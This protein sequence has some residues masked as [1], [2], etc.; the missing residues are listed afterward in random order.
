MLKQGTEKITYRLSIS[1]L[2]IILSLFAISIPL[3]IS[4]YQDYIKTKNALIEIEV[5][6][7]VAD[8]A[9]KI[10][11]ERGPANKAMSSHAEDLAKNRQA[12][13]EYRNG[14]DQQVKLTISAL[15]HAGFNT[16]AIGVQQDVVKRL[17]QGRQ[18]VDLYLNTPFTQRKAIQFDQ[19]ILHMFNAWDATHDVLKKVVMYSKNK[20]SSLTESYTLILILADL[21]DQAG[22]VASN[23]MAHVS[24]NEPL[25]NTN[26]ARS[27]QTQKQVQYLWDLV[28]TIQLE[29]EKTPEFNTLHQKVKTEFI[30]QGL[31]MIM[32]LIQESTQGQAY[33]LQGTALTDRISRYFSTVIDL[34]KYLL[35][36]SVHRAHQHLQQA[37]QKLIWSV[38][39]TVL[40]LFAAFFTMIYA[41]KRVFIPLIQ[42]RKMILNLVQHNGKSLALDDEKYHKSSEFFA[43][44]EAIYKLKKMLVQR[45][46]FESQLKD[47]AST[48]ALTGV[49][50]RVVLE[51]YIQQLERDPALL[52]QLC[53]IV[54]DIDNFKTV[55]DRYGHSLGD[56]V[57]VEVA[58]C[59]KQ[60]I[61]HSD[62]IVRFGGDEFLVLI[63]DL[64][65]EQVYD[66]AEKIR[67]DVANVIIVT[68]EIE[69][70]LT[71]SVSI[72]VAGL[73]TSW[74]DL[75]HRADQSLFRAKAL[76]KNKVARS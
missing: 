57:I 16:L 23:V 70:Q 10:S 14:V 47:I 69:Q 67:K 50:N 49:S 68:P 17:V 4:S 35:D 48:D 37:K 56:G 27:L 75:F 45:D 72:G 29:E 76:G 36:K 62:L 32:Q 34:Q 61:G 31:P 22:R 52:L 11:R 12:L 44:F 55:N 60:N 28:Y 40:S 7:T 63:P 54:I 39:I 24:F 41:R 42:A 53:L 74:K 46:V 21:R 38:S 1:M 65:L 15:Q 58:S 13:L 19:A 51:E 30:D 33:H 8:L 25:P 6:N 64:E 66:I 2:V 59:L 73:A 5:L 71:V 20:D 3:V 9:N 18:H 43:L 26:I